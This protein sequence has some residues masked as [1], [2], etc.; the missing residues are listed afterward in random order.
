MAARNIEPRRST[1]RLALTLSPQSTNSHRSQPL[2]SLQAID[3]GGIE[4]QAGQ[5]C[6]P[7]RRREIPSPALLLEPPALFEFA[8]RSILN[9]PAWTKHLQSCKAISE[10]AGTHQRAGQRRGG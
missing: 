5:G 9:V 4:S 3:L 10:P 1:A 7:Q 8:I 2:S 6:A